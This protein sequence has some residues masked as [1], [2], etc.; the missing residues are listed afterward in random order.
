MPKILFKPQHINAT[1]KDLEGNDGIGRYIFLPGSDGR[2]KEITEHFNKVKVKTHPRGHNLYLG[3]LDYE[4]QPIEVAAISS[5]MGCPS[6]EIIVHELFKLGAKR[7][8]RIGTAATL[9][10]N[11][12]STGSLVNVLASARDEC[13]STHYAPLAVPAVASLEFVTAILLAAG[14]LELAEKLH[15]GTVHCKSSLYAREFAEGPRA[16]ENEQYLNLLAQSG[17]LATEMETAT[18]FIQTQIYNYQLS[19]EGYAPKNHVLA[20]AILGIVGTSYMFEESPAV[21]TAIKDSIQLA[22][23]T[24]KTLAAQ[25]LID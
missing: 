4:G 17:V 7:F 3:Q 22:L 2:A 20:G 11:F 16:L 25:E 14:R 1:Q 13:T 21:E 23:E 6:V 24:I 18:L 19:H 5:G 8:L 15:T 10:P 9:Q 12:I